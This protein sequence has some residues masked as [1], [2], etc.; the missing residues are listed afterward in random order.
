MYNICFYNAVYESER[1]GLDGL[2]IQYSC[3][4]YYRPVWYLSRYCI[5]INQIRFIL[6]I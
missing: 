4:T 2:T 3:H 1:A 5:Q 6:Y